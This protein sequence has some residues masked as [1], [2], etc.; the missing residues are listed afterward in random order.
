[1]EL[2]TTDLV[3]HLIDTSNSCPIC[4]PLRR[5]PFALQGMVDETVHKMM[6]QR[7]IQNSN[8]PWAAQ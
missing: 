7:V 3:T 5:I 2:G 8:S 4:Q 6:A 1:M